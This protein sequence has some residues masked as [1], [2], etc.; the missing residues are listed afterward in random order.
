MAIE[1]FGIRKIEDQ[2][3]LA[4]SPVPVPVPVSVSVSVPEWNSG[5]IS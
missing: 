3:P 4:T 1:E 5:S 2:H